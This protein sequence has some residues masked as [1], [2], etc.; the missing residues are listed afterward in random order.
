MRPRQTTRWPSLILVIGL[1]G[2]LS[3]CAP[4]T[5]KA[6]AE[7]EDPVTV[8]VLDHGRHSSLVLPTEPPGH[9]LRYS[10][11]DWSFYVERNT[12]PGA[13]LAAVFA[14]TR[15]A[16]GRQEL[17]GADLNAAVRTSLRV[18]LEDIHHIE[19]PATRAQALIEKLEAIWEE[20]ADERVDSAAWGMSFVHHPDAYTLRHNSNHVVAQWLESLDVEVSK[21][22]V[23]SNWQVETR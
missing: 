10:Y 6:P 11:G 14:S 23:L 13:M 19:V 9:W 18:P 1:A 3:G 22:P 16:L 7:P 8:A 2:L 20:G 17:E 4:T 21:K 12:G 5:L 15:A